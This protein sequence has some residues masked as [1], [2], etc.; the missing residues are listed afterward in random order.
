MKK[1][2]IP[3][4]LTAVVLVAG[5]FAFMPVQQASTVHTTVASASSG[6]TTVTYSL[7]GLPDTST[8]VLIDATYP[9]QITSAHIT[10]TLPSDSTGDGVCDAGDAPVAAINLLVGVA[11]ATLGDLADDAAFANTGIEAS[12]LDL[13]GDGD[14][15]DAGELSCVYHATVTAPSTIDGVALTSIT[16]I[17]IQIGTA[18][19]MP[20]DSSVTITATITT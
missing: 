19:P 10:A 20:D 17:A 14:T 6:L 7:D 15:T 13:N 2:A 16:D 3:I 11:P 9:G 1:Y 18:G 8:L 4:I 12:A 5:I